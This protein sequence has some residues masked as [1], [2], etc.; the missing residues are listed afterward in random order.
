MG[1]LD[2]IE[3][4]DVAPRNSEFEPIPA[5][6][7]KAGVVSSEVKPT[8]RGDGLILR[9]VHCIMESGPYEG[10]ELY[11]NLNVQNPNEKA[12]QIG[13]GM[14]ASLAR[15]VGLTGIPDDSDKLHNKMHV[16]KVV[17]SPGNGTNPV[18]GEAYGPKNEI[19]GFF[20]VDAAK[21]VAAPVAA[22]VAKAVPTK[23]TEDEDLPDFLK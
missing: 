13:R 23:A 14:I 18:T 9:L 7:Y 10:R 17:V 1:N 15:A 5:G 12:Q 6:M 16:I 22:A 11:T 19:K 4:K 3:N 20:A 8:S 21:K 2:C